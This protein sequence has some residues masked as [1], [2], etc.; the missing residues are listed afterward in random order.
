MNVVFQIFTRTFIHGKLLRFTTRNRTPG[1]RRSTHRL[2]RAQN[3]PATLKLRPSSV[4]P[5]GR[6][7]RW[8]TTWQDTCASSAVVNENSPVT[9]ARTSTRKTSV[10]VDTWRIITM[11]SCPSRRGTTA[12]GRCTI[13]LISESDSQENFAGRWLLSSCRDELYREDVR[14]TCAKDDLVPH[15]VIIELKILRRRIVHESNMQN[16]FCIEQTF[17]TLLAFIVF[18]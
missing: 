5:V 7:T 14:K 15:K 12:R 2:E 9:Y 16:V 11:S 13:M 4:L 6:D 8:S 17:R 18:A 1:P 3:I 10:Y